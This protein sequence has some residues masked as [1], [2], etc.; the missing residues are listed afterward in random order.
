M[1]EKRLEI[2]VLATLQSMFGVETD[3]ALLEA[4]N[5]LLHT[6]PPTLTVSL[7]PTG[8]IGLAWTRN[9][10][11]LDEWRLWANIANQIAYACNQKAIE[12]TLPEE[13]QSPGDLPGTES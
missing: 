11:T 7:S 8:T 3:E 1:T 12:T 5:G 4:I 13:E 2:D 9:P 6:A 10:T